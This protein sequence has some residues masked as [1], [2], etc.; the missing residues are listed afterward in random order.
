VSAHRYGPA[1]VDSTV[2]LLI[3]AVERGDAGAVE[4]LFTTLYSELHR[5]AQRELAGR[6][7]NIGLGVTTLLHE[8]YLDMAA[9]SDCPPKY[10]NRAAMIGVDRLSSMPLV[11]ATAPG[12][13][14]C[15]AKTL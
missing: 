6:G 10:S 4:S 3:G 7:A 1:S 5:L 12:C 9:R 8:A 11:V 14:L 15:C 2:S 13:G